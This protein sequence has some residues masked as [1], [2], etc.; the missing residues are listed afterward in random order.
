MDTENVSYGGRMSRIELK[1]VAFMG[2]GRIWKEQLRMGETK[3]RP[4]ENKIH[5]KV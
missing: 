2:L 5:R 4:R 1:K 3:K